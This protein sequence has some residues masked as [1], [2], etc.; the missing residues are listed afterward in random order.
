MAIR[1]QWLQLPVLSR[2]P[3]SQTNY[4]CAAFSR[5]PYAESTWEPTGPE[6]FTR[7]QH[8]IQHRSSAVPDR[9]APSQGASPRAFCPDDLQLDMRVFPALLLQVHGAPGMNQGAMALAVFWKVTRL[10]HPNQPS[11]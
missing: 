8:P 7:T 4:P 9:V 6:E 2:V 11:P 5:P 10:H 1:V 3:P